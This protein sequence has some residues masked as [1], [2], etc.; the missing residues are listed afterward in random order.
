MIG[1]IQRL[2]DD[3]RAAFDNAYRGEKLTLFG[4]AEPV[5]VRDSESETT[6]P[7]IVNVK[8][9]CH[10]VY[11]ALDYSDVTIYSRLQNIA[12]EDDPTTSFGSRKGYKQSADVSIVVL[13]K[14][15]LG[16]YNLERLLADAIS[17]SGERVLSSSDFNAVQVWSSEFPGVPYFIN[18]DYFIFK[19]NFR[20]NTSTARCK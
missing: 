9:E 6:S 15:K 8:G 14:R 10:V 5:L 18:P 1:A 7:A 3:I 4:L 11:S 17:A 20:I 12:Y 2:N 19:I 16:I 13:G